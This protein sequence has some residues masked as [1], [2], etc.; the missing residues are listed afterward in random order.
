MKHLLLPFTLI[1]SIVTTIRNALFDLGVLKSTAFHRPVICVGN[2]T[3]G[4]TGKSPC[5]QYLAR[6]LQPHTRLGLIS[7]GYK[8]KSKGLQRVE[9]H[10]TAD[11]AGDEPLQFKLQFPRAEVAVCA[12]R[13]KG[14]A[15]LLNQA[16]VE[17]VLMDDGYQHRKVKAGLN[18][19]LIDYHRPIWKD[20]PFPSGR[21]RETRRGL[22][23]AQ[24]ILVNKCP[25]L[26]EPDAR[27]Q[28]LKKIRPKPGQA[29]F[30]SAIQYKPLQPIIQEHAPI[31]WTPCPILAVSG[32]AQPFSFHE[33]LKKLSPHVRVLQFPDH[34]AFT[35]SNMQQIQKQ[36]ETHPSPSAVVMT[37]KDKVRMQHFSPESYSFLAQAWYLPI[38]LQI[39]FEESSKF[40]QLILNYVRK[41]N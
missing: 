36:W 15:Y 1:F 31:D 28:L 18:L 2:I 6:L 5:I 13:V 32:I 11:H 25:G 33:Q 19:V 8:R 4:G 12:N 14:I 7:R 30:F 35:P 37:E 16:K 21:L 23:R 10:S 29:V 9:V 34:H 39:L 38:E 22:D 3:V 26:L 27:D 20:Y 17:T 24:I 41:N 40:D